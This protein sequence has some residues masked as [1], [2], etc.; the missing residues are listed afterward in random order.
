M[1]KKKN[2]K[3]QKFPNFWGFKKKTEQNLSWENIVKKKHTAS[4]KL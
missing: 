2:P 3:I 1:G 4:Q